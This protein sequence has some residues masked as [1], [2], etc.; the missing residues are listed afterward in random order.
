MTS[1]TLAMTTTRM[2]RGLL[3]SAALLLQVAIA[4]EFGAAEG[5]RRQFIDKERHFAVDLPRGWEL[6][7]TF[8]GSLDLVF[9]V[10]S[11]RDSPPTFSNAVMFPNG[12]GA[13]MSIIPRSLLGPRFRSAGVP[14]LVAFEKRFAKE[15]AFVSRPFADVTPASG[16]TDAVEMIFDERALGR[17][18]ERRSRRALAFRYRGEPYLAR[19]F[20]LTGDKREAEYVRAF[21]EVIHSWQPTEYSH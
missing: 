20:Y 4:S 3:R 21:L 16:I 1:N 7:P 8:H 18:T 14:E 2:N 19:L 12:G 11:Q 9:N 6:Q 17:D 5:T 10:P 13:A 15:G